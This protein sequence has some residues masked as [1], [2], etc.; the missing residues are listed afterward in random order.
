[1]ARAMCSRTGCDKKL[2]SNN[3]TGECG[4]GCLSPDAPPAK[5]AKGVSTTTPASSTSSAPPSTPEPG[6]N[7]ARFR[8]VASA[9]GA[10]ADAVLEEFCGEWLKGVRAALDEAA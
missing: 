4:S 8:Q 6:A 3:K 7:M 5:R 9:V 1:M 10:D 2:R